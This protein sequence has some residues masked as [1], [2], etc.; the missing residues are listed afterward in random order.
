MS[1]N[2]ENEEVIGQNT[3]VI[4]QKDHNST[5]SKTQTVSTSEA[6]G[7]SESRAGGET[8]TA[9]TAINSMLKTVTS[10]QQTTKQKLQSPIKLS[11]TVSS[12]VMS[13]L[14]EKSLLSV[15]LLSSQ[16]TS[17]ASFTKTR[18]LAG[19]DNTNSGVSSA[20]THEQVASPVA[21][22]APAEE[23]QPKDT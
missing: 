17:L 12:N 15:T 6:K 9:N 2:P 22:L 10:I 4:P 19:A 20:T 18:N 23:E 14:I 5:D 1:S 21:D 3:A 8:S 7:S 11:F 13:R 16:V